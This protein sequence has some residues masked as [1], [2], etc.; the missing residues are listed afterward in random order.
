MFRVV[1]PGDL[2]EASAYNLAGKQGL[3]PSLPWP[4]WPKYPEM[5]RRNPHQRAYAIERT[6]APHLKTVV[7]LKPGRLLGIQVDMWLTV[8]GKYLFVGYQ[9]KAFGMSTMYP[10]VFFA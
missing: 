1:D 4:S 5:S 3:S 6:P 10:P 8:H 2:E 7:N 9:L